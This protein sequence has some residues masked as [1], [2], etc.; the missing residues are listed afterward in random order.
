MTDGLLVVEADIS[1]REDVQLPLESED[2]FHGVPFIHVQSD[3]E[4][5]IPEMTFRA[6]R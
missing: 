4:F 5:R 6:L 2:F 3:R 1:E